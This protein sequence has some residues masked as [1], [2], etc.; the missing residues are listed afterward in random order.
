MQGAGATVT[1]D[2]SLPW[3]THSTRPPCSWDELYYAKSPLVRV[4]WL[5][6]VTHFL[7]EEM[8]LTPDRTAV[9]DC[10]AYNGQWLHRPLQVR[11]E[12]PL[13][14]GALARESWTWTAS[15][16]T[17]ARLRGL[18]V[19]A[20]ARA[21]YELDGAAVFCYA[22]V[23]RRD[24]PLL[25]LL[26]LPP[27]LGAT[28]SSSRFDSWTTVPGAASKRASEC[29]CRARMCR[30]PP[31]FLAMVDAVAARVLPS[32]GPLPTA[33]RTAPLPS[34]AQRRRRR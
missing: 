19:D 25:L 9:G 18:C 6:Y 27:L 23:P 16:S 8:P 14:E 13:G 1:E 10:G 4:E 30:P 3:F 29:S 12:H 22:R 21:G 34:C 17:Q 11:I 31:C 7:L 28:T 33:T 5:D 32:C 24:R 2:D 15:R 26:L 20:M